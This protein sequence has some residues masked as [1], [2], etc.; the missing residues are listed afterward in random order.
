MRAG[1]PDQTWMRLRERVGS[2][3]HRLHELRHAAV[4]GLFEGGR[5]MADVGATS[6]HRELRMLSRDTRLRAADRAE[7]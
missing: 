4:T 6:A 5:G 2:N 7:R 1:G 3:D